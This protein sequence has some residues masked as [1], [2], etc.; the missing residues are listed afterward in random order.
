VE[1]VRFGRY[2]VVRKIGAGGMATVYLCRYEG[3]EGFRKRVAV[4]AIHPRHGDDPRFCDLFVREARL[5]ASLSHPHLVQVFDFGREGGRHFLVMEYVE[6]WNLAQAIAQARNR[7]LPVPLGVWRWWVHGILS[8]AGYLHSRGIVHRDI[9]PSNVL[10]SREGA[11]KLADFGVAFAA[12]SLAGPGGAAGKAGYT[13]PEVALGGACTPA[14]DL[15]AA[16]VTAAEVLLLRPLFGGGSRE[17]VLAR[18]GAHDETAVDLQEVPDVVRDILRR[19][20]ARDPA[21]RYAL[22]AEFAADLERAVPGPQNARAVEQYW[23]VLFP[24]G[25]GE[26]ETAAPEQTE[27]PAGGVL[28]RERRPSYGSSRRLAA[29]LGVAAVLAAG[30]LLSWRGTRSFSLPISLPGAGRPPMAGG[31]AEGA[32]REEGGAETGAGRARQK[33]AAT[34]SPGNSSVEAVV[35]PRHGATP[36][37]GGAGAGGIAPG[38]AGGGAQGRGSESARPEVLIE[39]DPPG[40]SVRVEGGPRLGRTPLGVDPRA[41]AGRTLLLEMEGYEP[42]SVPADALAVV[43]RFR[44]E[45]VRVMGV[46]EAIQ[47]IPWAKVYDGDRYLGETPLRA[48]ALPAGEHRLRFVNE[49]LGVERTE[50]IVVRPGTNPKVIVPLA[51]PR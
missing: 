27:A 19:G 4:K 8:A 48:V 6:G 32:A 1:P 23:D 51:A 45:L 18:V 31:H 40:A 25:C 24:A 11:V 38:E 35:P 49:P 7:A 50:A 41:W 5:A 47:A 37:P 14:S 30:G 9:S 43:H 42:A 12:R 3:E 17:E 33:T 36:S 22:A 15:F 21:R 44:M 2:R 10:L 13:A 39:T 29:G 20:L 26:E 16:A 46:V 34:P 28:A